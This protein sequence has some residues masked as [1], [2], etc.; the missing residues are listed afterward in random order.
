MDS[1]TLGPIPKIDFTRT[2]EHTLATAWEL[3][4]LWFSVNSL[5]KLRE[6]ILNSV[7]NTSLRPS[8]YRLTGNLKLLRFRLWLA[9]VWTEVSLVQTVFWDILLETVQF[10]LYQVHI[11]TA[12]PSV[13]TVFAKILSTFK[14]NSG[15]FWNTGHRLDLLPRHP[16][17]LQRLPKQRRLLKSNFLLN[18]DWP[19]A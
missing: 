12:W 2:V 13:Q 15:I 6:F 17:G 19:S 3:S 4:D 5:S 7:Q 14:R 18:T 16:D 10:Y 11:W 9:S 1:F 8:I